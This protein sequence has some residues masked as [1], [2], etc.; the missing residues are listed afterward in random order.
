MIESYNYDLLYY[1]KR[2]LWLN[3]IIMIYSII[4]KEY[5]G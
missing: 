2:I 3:N 1:F 4:L 5:Y